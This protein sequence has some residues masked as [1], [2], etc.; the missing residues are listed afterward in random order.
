[1]GRK[2]FDSIG[3]ALP[4]RTNYVMTKSG[5]AFGRIVEAGAFPLYTGFHELPET[6]WLIGGASL[7]DSALD[8]GL[9][10]EL[11]ITLVHTLSG[12]DVR[13]KHD[14]YNWKMFAVRELQKGRPWSLV[15]VQS[16]EASDPE[17]TFITLVRT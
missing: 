14:L 7:Y 11:H 16:A 3:R 5:D 17:A 2:T 15:S 6:A 4:N 1:M 10:K 9:I 13:I 8:K 12:A